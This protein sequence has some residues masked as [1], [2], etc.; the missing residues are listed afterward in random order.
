MIV[1]SR[2]NRCGS[3]DLSAAN[4]RI[5]VRELHDAILACGSLPSRLIRQ[6]LLGE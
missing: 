2:D 3:F 4:A 6:R 1:K 5:S